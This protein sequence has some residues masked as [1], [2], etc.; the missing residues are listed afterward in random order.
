[1]IEGIEG[2]DEI[3]GIDGIDGIDYILVRSSPCRP[4]P[5]RLVSSSGLKGLRGLRGLIR[6]WLEVRLVAP[7]LVAL[8]LPTD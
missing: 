6:F 1:M 2:I 5:C 4:S 8:S 3:E 7:R